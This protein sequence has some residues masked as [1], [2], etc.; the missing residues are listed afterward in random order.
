MISNF[1]I[2][3]DQLDIVSVA[4]DYGI[5]INRNNKAHCPLHTDKTPSLSFKN[6]RFRCFSCDRGGDVTD[7]V[8][9]L[10]NQL[11]VDA[12]REL[13][14]SYHLGLDVDAPVSP[15]IVRRRTLLRE[16]RER[17]AKWEQYSF[18]ILVAYLHAMEEWKVT[19]CP[20]H[21][22]DVI[23]RRYVE[24]L[25]KHDFI[26]YVLDEIFIQGTPEMKAEFITT[27]EQ[28][29]RSIEQRLIWEGISYAPR[30]ETGNWTVEPFRP[31]VVVGSPAAHRAA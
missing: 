13:N 26:A 15:D 25:H 27:H 29:I 10:T 2:V 3:K 24:A 14:H 28:M 5:K 12:L 16:Q 1:D 23:D 21:P 8:G 6:N 4:Q 20:K 30:N 9:L 19:Y 18:C 17:N 31:V 11:P 22:D 7:L